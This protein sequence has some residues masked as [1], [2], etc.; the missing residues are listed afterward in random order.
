VCVRALTSGRLGLLIKIS[1][2]NIRA[3][4]AA[5]GFSKATLDIMVNMT[6]GLPWPLKAVPQ[7]VLYILQRFEVCLSAGR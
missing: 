6:D 3:T 4:D 7:T 2:A 5:Y 1:S